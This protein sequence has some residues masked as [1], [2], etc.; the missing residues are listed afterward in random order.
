MSWNP[1]VGEVVVHIFSGK[2]LAIKVVE[3][4]PGWVTTDDGYTRQTSS[5]RPLTAI[6][7]GEE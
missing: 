2:L 5:I 3:D 4:L 1:K 7:R 6:E